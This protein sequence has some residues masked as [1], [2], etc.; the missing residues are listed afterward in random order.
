MR[1]LSASIVFLTLLASVDAQ[2]TV[3]SL[4]DSGPGTLRQAILDANAQAG[5]DSIVM[6]PGLSGTIN[7]ATTLPT[8]TSGLTIDGDSDGDPAT[9]DIEISAGNACRIMVVNGVDLILVNMTLRDGNAGPNGEGG[10]IDFNSSLLS[11]F[12]VT[13]VRFINNRSGNGGAVK[14]HGIGTRIVFTDCEFDKNCILSSTTLPGEGGAI[15]VD[16]ELNSM[17]LSTILTQG[18]T[19]TDNTS[20]GPGG[21]LSF[22]GVTLGY[23]IAQ[24]LFERNQS[25]NE[26]GGAFMIQDGNTATS[27]HRTVIH[28]DHNVFR[29]NSAIFGGAGRITIDGSETYTARVERS[30]FTSNRAIL[31]A[32]A[33][34]ILTGSGP[35]QNE[36]LT[37]SNC[38]FSGQSAGAAGGDSCFAGTAR[39]RNTNVDMDSCT[40]VGNSAIGANLL[41]L[42]LV[43]GFDISDGDLTLRNTIFDR[44]SGV[45]T[46]LQDAE[47]LRHRGSG[48]FTDADHNLVN[49]TIDLQLGGLNGAN[50]IIGISPFLGPLASSPLNVGRSNAA[51]PMPVHYPGPG[52]PVVDAGASG[53][54]F[55]QIW[56]PRAGGGADEIGAIEGSRAIP[57]IALSRSGSSIPDGGMDALGGRVIGSARTLIYTVDNSLGTGGLFLSSL[58]FTNHIN[59]TS[60]DLVG[61]LPPIIPAGGSATLVFRFQVLAV[62][63]FSFDVDI[64]SAAGDGTY[65]IAVAGQG[66]PLT[67][68]AVGM[69]DLTINGQG[70][71]APSCT[72]LTFVSP[73][74]SLAMRVSTSAPGLAVAILFRSTPCSPQS[75]TVGSCN[76]TTFDLVY[77]PNITNIMGVTGADGSFATSFPVSTVPFEI[78]L[79]TQALI[80]H[81]CG[82]LFTQ[83]FDVTIR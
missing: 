44:N 71:G 10:A 55:D 15:A 33:L 70:S 26:G 83:A 81:P 18:S 63:A 57:D 4:A 60:I 40:I 72:A 74:P 52:S 32:A 42:G 59:V 37:L 30:T 1:V 19:F 31:D 79:S 29:D 3:S 77:T 82:P 6:S 62:G 80:A 21:A 51:E 78:K 50:N 61:G 9:C 12:L 22:R 8:I 39:I 13:N 76:Q 64:F 46:G 25:T 73:I 14:I 23:A 36:S 11:V 48:T 65:D 41:G 56:T 58:N 45:A 66:I 28:I 27:A 67:L 69:N 35:G 34:D 16:L 7:L 43:G 75:L 2:I 5:S 49:D 68:G 38:T 24:C 20:R 54:M 53:Q 47:A 17:E